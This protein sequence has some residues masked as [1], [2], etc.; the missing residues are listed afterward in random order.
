[1]FQATNLIN[2]AEKL[3]KE[4]IENPPPTEADVEVDK[5]GD[6]KLFYLKM[7]GDYPAGLENGGRER[8]IFFLGFC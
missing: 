8:E 1:M 6:S 4:L 7:K 5:A 3:E 2:E